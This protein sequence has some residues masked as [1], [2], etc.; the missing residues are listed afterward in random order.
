MKEW[1]A[2]EGE[3]GRRGRW[4]KERTPNGSRR[5]VVG[6]CLLPRHALHS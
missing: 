3:V 2:T 4:E 5:K 1:V 6:E